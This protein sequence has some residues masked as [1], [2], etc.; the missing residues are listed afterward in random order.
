MKEKI[1][2]ILKTDY[3]DDMKAKMIQIE[4]NSFMLGVAKE[5]KTVTDMINGLFINVYKPE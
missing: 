1:I 2:E 5:S 3:S 4:F